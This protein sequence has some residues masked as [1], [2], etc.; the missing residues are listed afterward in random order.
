MGR[1]GTEH[2]EA[3]GRWGSRKRGDSDGDTDL[4]PNGLCFSP[5]GSTRNYCR[6]EEKSLFNLT[7]QS[8]VHEP[9][10]PVSPGSS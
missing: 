9:E 1:K 4:C 2:K 5:E 8:V 10:A 3:K 7:T 6:K